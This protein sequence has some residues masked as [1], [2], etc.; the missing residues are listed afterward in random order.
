MTSNDNPSTIWLA[1]FHLLRKKIKKPHRA[2]RN[3]FLMRSQRYAQ[4]QIDLSE[5]ENKEIRWFDYW[6]L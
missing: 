3:K 2:G 5:Q 6:N 1:L 4:S